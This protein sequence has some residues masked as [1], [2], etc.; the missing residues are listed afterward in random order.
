M[1]NGLA[2]DK[3]SKEYIAT[4]IQGLPLFQPRFS[5]L[6]GSNNSTKLQT[7]AI[8]MKHSELVEDLT[9]LGWLDAHPFVDS[10]AECL[11]GTAAAP[12]KRCTTISATDQ[13]QTDRRTA[14][15]PAMVTDV[16]QTSAE[17][18][19]ILE[20]SRFRTERSFPASC[21]THRHKQTENI[22]NADLISSANDQE[23][24]PASDIG[25]DPL[26]SGPVQSS[27]PLCTDLL[28]N[29][30]GGGQLLHGNDEDI[31]INSDQET[32]QPASNI[33]INTLSFGAAQS[34]APL[35]TDL[36]S[37]GNGRQSLLNRMGSTPLNS[38]ASVPLC[39]ELLSS[40]NGPDMLNRNDKETIFCNRSVQDAVV[41]QSLSTRNPV[42]LQKQSSTSAQPTQESWVPASVILPEMACNYDAASAGFLDV[43][44]DGASSG[45]LLHSCN[46]ESLNLL[47]RWEKRRQQLLEKGW[48]RKMQQV[49]KTEKKRL[50]RLQ[51]NESGDRSSDRVRRA[52]E[53]HAANSA[54]C[55]LSGAAQAAIAGKCKA[56]REETS[57]LLTEFVPSLSKPKTAELRAAGCMGFN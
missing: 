14:C 6:G 53:D 4:H 38:Q 15:Y 52:A 49:E 30:N 47:E 7:T 9:A 16:V 41:Q 12:E 55:M 56:L 8:A 17:G 22:L 5:S 37:R 10:T 19:P 43:L 27:A 34:V 28:P 21:S 2:P 23:R 18:L 29:T 1:A 11:L 25:I 54:G 24:A 32:A 35:C 48:K 33:E 45:Q 42:D 20:L 46:E 50:P 51:Q 3:L 31:L 13:L 36:V 39:A 26:S 40:T 44:T 57:K